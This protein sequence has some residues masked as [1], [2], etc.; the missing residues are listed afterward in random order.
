MNTEGQSC[1]LDLIDTDQNQLAGCCGFIRVNRIEKEAQLVVIFY[2][3]YIDYIEESI[4]YILKVLRTSKY[5]LN[6][7]TCNVSGLCVT[8]ETL[9]ILER[10]NFYD[11]TD[12]LQ[13]EGDNHPCYMRF[14]VDESVRPGRRGDDQS[15]ATGS[16]GEIC[17]FWARGY[18]RFGEDC[19]YLHISA[20]PSGSLALT[21][22]V[23]SQPGTPALSSLG[24]P[25]SSPALSSLPGPGAMGTVQSA[26]PAIFMP[27]SAVPGAGSVMGV[28]G[29]PLG[30]VRS[31][32]LPPY[33]PAAAYAPDTSGGFESPQFAFPQYPYASY[34]FPSFPYTSYPWQQQMLGGSAGGS[35][36]AGGG[37]SAGGVM[38]PS[39]GFT[40]QQPAVYAP[41]QMMYGYSTMPGHQPMQQS[42]PFQQLPQMQGQREDSAAA[43]AA[44]AMMYPSAQMV[45][46]IAQQQAQQQAQAQ[47]QAQGQSQQ[48]QDPR[49]GVA[50]P[51]DYMFYPSAP[52]HPL[53]Y[54]YTSQ[55]PQQQ[56]Q[57]QQ[58]Q[59]P[60]EEAPRP[61]DSSFSSCS[62]DNPYY[63]AV[64]P[65]ASTFPPGYPV[66]GYP[67]VNYPY[68]QYSQHPAAASYPS[69]ID[70][71]EE[72][73]MS[74][75]SFGQS[76]SQSFSRSQ[77]QDHEQRQGAGPSLVPEASQN[78]SFDSGPQEKHSNGGGSG[79]GGGGETNGGEKDKQS[80]RAEATQMTAPRSHSD[81][82]SAA[83]VV[84]GHVRTDKTPPAPLAPPSI[85]AATTA[86]TSTT[87]IA[88]MHQKLLDLVNTAPPAVLVR[89]RYNEQHVHSAAEQPPLASAAPAMSAKEAASAAASTELNRATPLLDSHVVSSNGARQVDGRD[90]VSHYLT[91]QDLQSLND[92]YQRMLNPAQYHNRF[93]RIFTHGHFNLG[94]HHSDDVGDASCSDT[95]GAT[96][97]SVTIHAT[98]RV[99]I[100]RI[101][102]DADNHSTISSQTSSSPSEEYASELGFEVHDATSE[103]FNSNFHQYQ[104]MSPPDQ[105]EG[106]W[107]E[108]CEKGL[109]G[110][111][112]SRQVQRRE[113][114]HRHHR[115][116]YLLRALQMHRPR[117][118]LN[119]ADVIDLISPFCGSAAE[120]ARQGTESGD[121]A[122][123]I[124]LTDLVALSMQ[125]PHERRPHK[126]PGDTRSTA[127]ELDLSTPSLAGSRRSAVASAHEA[128]SG[129]GMG[130][131]DGYESDEEE[132][133]GDGESVLTQPAPYSGTTVAK[134]EMKGKHGA[135]AGHNLTQSTTQSGS[136]SVQGKPA[137]RSFAI[138]QF[139]PAMVQCVVNGRAQNGP[140]PSLPSLLNV[141]GLSSAQ[142]SVE[143][144]LFLNAGVV[145]A[146]CA[147]KSN[148]TAQF[149]RMQMQQGQQMSSQGQRE[150]L[151]QR[152]SHAAQG[153]QDSRQPIVPPQQAQMSASMQQLQQRLL[154]QQQIFHQ[155][156]RQLQQQTPVGQIPEP[157][158]QQIP[159]TGGPA[160]SATD[161][162]PQPFATMP[163]GAVHPQ[164]LQYWM[165]QQQ[166]VY[167]QQFF[168]QQQAQAAAGAEATVETGGSALSVA[169]TGGAYAQR[170]PLQ[171]P[172]MQ[173]EEQPTESSPAATVPVGASY[174]PPERLRPPP[175][176]I[177]PHGA[178]VP[179]PVV[180]PRAQFAPQPY[181]QYVPQG[182]QHPQ[183]TAG[184][185]VVT[186]GHSQGQAQAQG[187]Q[188]QG[189][190]TS[191]R[192][193]NIRSTLAQQ[194]QQQQP[195]LRQ[196]Q[197]Q[198]RVT[199]SAGAFSRPPPI[200]P[201]AAA[202]APTSTAGPALQTRSNRTNGTSSEP[203]SASQQQPT[204]PQLPAKKRKPR[205]ASRDGSGVSA[206]AGS[207]G[208]DSPSPFPRTYPTFQAA[209]A[210]TGMEQRQGQQQGG[211]SQQ[212]QQQ[213]QQMYYGQ[214]SQGQPSQGPGQGQSLRKQQPAAAAVPVPVRRP[215]APQTQPGEKRA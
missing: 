53:P 37:D 38:T 184:M 1:L 59:E 205:K 16:V 72:H 76:V 115:L 42:Q 17:R 94:A 13:R 136:S 152:E 144:L 124:D 212:R 201:R 156:Q 118:P 68:P 20:V 14:V 52:T 40:Q 161:P 215:P 171:P 211:G 89:L 105:P 140:W 80:A 158:Y 141:M 163:P 3:Q 117:G 123:V 129:N 36:I 66:G 43:G 97:S 30:G 34:S 204:Q 134:A 22:S 45:S 44:S 128:T 48:G 28:N 207:S 159:V 35:G 189:G 62:T 177:T 27:V 15:S 154:A 81:D 119:P 125:E 210:T 54:P 187:P 33:Y 56:Q 109:S 175:I 8:K 108:R 122:C 60:D 51:S 79:R 114:A 73:N 83:T 132:G 180:P 84:T 178:S 183:N 96:E 67:G 182:P 78:S 113:T 162:T 12:E 196:P 131:G 213:E 116:R 26:V 23:I 147:E 146:Y 127:M 143:S 190:A 198:E 93:E 174:G 65:P 49:L 155:Q 193:Y 135:E 100:H 90:G 50:Q 214:G 192:Q 142:R 138:R 145:Q 86:A 126:M 2:E 106:S 160:V 46:L 112:L 176:Q 25:P 153:S 149:H 99:P 104:D 85:P 47:A 191:E 168:M 188:G 164:Q 206:S 121:N 95:A 197:E 55:Q 82:Q 107:R 137:G 120:P 32:M 19:R 166:Q 91:A 63:D 179:A 69:S 21:G 148:I 74:Q 5:A 208:Q 41:A 111:A 64:E 61:Q 167:M 194:Q 11:A 200:Y 133:D 87:A 24:P 173:R 101:D 70:G 195:A 130:N 75:L 7:L 103:D 157:S 58:G 170:Q 6:V 172:P 92:Y 88:G 185:S 186:Q 110:R 199:T 31:N 29:S 39:S 98:P 150:D 4:A 102:G 10:L 18:C 203:D 77:D 169:N 181:P 9:G 165:Q 71:T 139:T 202:P 57:Q 151:L 209:A